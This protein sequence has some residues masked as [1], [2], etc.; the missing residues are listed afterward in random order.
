MRKLFL[1][2]LFLSIILSAT[3]HSC[4][5][6]TISGTINGYQQSMVTLY[7]IRGDLRLP[8]DSAS[9]NQDGHFQFVTRSWY[10][11]GMYELKL[12]DNQSLKIIFNHQDV[13]FVSDGLTENDNLRFIHSDE[14]ELWYAYVHL[15]SVVRERQE[16]IKPILQQY[17][18]ESLF[19]AQSAAEFNRLQYSLKQKADSIYNQR[20]ETLAARLIRTDVPPI[21]PL[22][23]DF[24][25]QKKQLIFHFFDQTDFADTLLLQ[26]D[27]LTSKMIEFL[28]LHQSPNLDM[29]GLQLAFI[30]GLDVIFEKASVQQATYLF[31]LE[32]FI[33]GFARMGFT[34]IT[35][36][37]STLPHFNSEC[38]DLQTITDIERIAGPHRRIMTGSQAPELSMSTITGEAFSLEQTKGQL[39][40]LVFWSV[41]CPHCISI[42][43][44]L[45]KLS[46]DFPQLHMLSFVLSN[47]NH[48]LNEIIRNEALQ[49][50]HL[51]DGLGWESPVAQE[52]MVYGTPTLIVLD[53]NNLIVSKPS[54]VAEARQSIILHL[55][56]Q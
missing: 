54:S 19:Y 31:A 56:N 29:P 46:T 2:T 39:K 14:N 47:D 23:L 9:T 28:A 43:P 3:R 7:A 35:D 41:N 33:E 27:V 50:T 38:T 30:R 51:S 4:A 21:I 34:A 12:K 49:W 20:S 52:Y 40:L 48:K 18:T 8:L 55:Q 24:E 37:L 11:P 44:E 42:L 45:K 17:P 32:Y 15:K 25:N 26:S 36:Y 10:R 16:I 13:A 53:E 1:T 22:E 6:Q 5:Q